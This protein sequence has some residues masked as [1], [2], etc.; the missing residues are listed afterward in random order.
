V[1]EKVDPAAF[2]EVAGPGRAGFV[3]KF[4]GDNYSC[5]DFLRVV[6]LKGGQYGESVRLPIVFKLLIACL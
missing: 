4:G 3:D 1:P 5:S 2:P 6:C